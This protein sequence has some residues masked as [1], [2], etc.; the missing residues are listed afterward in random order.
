MKWFYLISCVVLLQLLSITATVIVDSSPLEKRARKL[1]GRFLHITDI[2]LDPKYLEGADPDSLCHR[3]GRKKYSSVGKYGALHT[4]CDAPTALVQATFQ[5]LKK[6]IKNIDFIIYTGD[7]VRHDRDDNLPLKQ[8]EIMNGHKKIMNFFKSTYDLSQIPL[9]PTIGN[10]DGYNHNDV[11]KNDKIFRTLQ[12]IWKPLKLNLDK[13]FTAGG[14][15]THDVIKNKLTVINLNSMYFFEKN[16]DVSDCDSSSSPGNIQMK[17]LEGKL[18]NLAKKKGAHQAYIIGHIPPI[19][20]DGSRLYKDEC[21]KRYFNLLGKYSNVISGHFTGHTNNDNLNAVITTSSTSFTFLAA[22]DKSAIK[23]TS[24]LNNTPVALFNAPSILPKL[25]PAFRVYKYN[26]VKGKYPVGTIRDWDQ[27]FLDLEKA[28]KRRKVN[29][30]V[31]YKASKLYGTD[32][33]NGKG[34]GVAILN[35]ASSSTARDNYNKFARVS[36]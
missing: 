17:W 29:Y 27:Y 21:Y 5:F 23:K 6:N 34:L 16:D 32:H 36:V 12:T 33:F 25:N 22:N 10:N 35:V 30:Q 14:Y 11:E 7:T 24:A 9:L 31:E 1:T 15:Y 19:D 26:T 2:H 4:D 8:S 20:D 28:N 13:T 3:K 18:K